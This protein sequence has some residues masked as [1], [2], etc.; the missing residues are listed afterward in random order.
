MLAAQKGGDLRCKTTN[1][2]VGGINDKPVA[3]HILLAYRAGD[4]SVLIH[5]DS[6]SPS[7]GFND[8]LVLP[9][10]ANIRE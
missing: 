2:A 10:L 4:I 5:T 1:R 7:R 9:E 6:S 3:L 8:V